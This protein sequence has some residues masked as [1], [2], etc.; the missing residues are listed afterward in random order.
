MRTIVVPARKRVQF[1]WRGIQVTDQDLVIFPRGTDLAATSNP[2][3]YVYTCS[4]P[5]DL[6]AAIS[7]TQEFGELDELRGNASV[8]RCR[9]TAMESLRRCLQ[10]LCT[11]I[12][13]RVSLTQPELVD[14]VTR[15]LPLQLLNAIAAAHDACS[16]TTTQKREVALIRAEAY[17]VVVSQQ[18]LLG[19]EVAGVCVVAATWRLTVIRA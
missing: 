14:D 7:D 11:R 4:F 3:F 18:E 2:N 12:R 17:C 1:V 8:I 9:A 5:E 10:Q 16:V 15:V 6:L 13:N 19:D